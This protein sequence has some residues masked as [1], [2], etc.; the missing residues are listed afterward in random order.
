MNFDELKKSWQEQSTEEDLHNPNLQQY[1]E[2]GNIM[3]KLRRNIKREF[4]SWLLCVIFLI[5]VPMLPFYKIQGYAAFAYYFFIVQICLSS[6]LYYRRF[7]YLIKSAGQIELLASREHLL[8]LYYDLKY[9][10][11]TYRIVAYVMIPQAL[12][13]YLIMIGRNKAIE[14]FEKLYHFKE[15]YQQDPDF[16][17]W[18]ILSAIASIAIIAVITELM[19]RYYYGDYVKQIKENLDQM[20]SD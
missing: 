11:E 17:L 7:Y 13:L 18:M 20:E 6:L 5:A 12:F 8:K 3:A 14:W 15:T 19:I 2:V 10:V 1:K 9:A 4:V 16:I